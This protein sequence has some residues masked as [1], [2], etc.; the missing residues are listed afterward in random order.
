MN[1]LLKILLLFV[2]ILFLNKN[3]G[4][5]AGTAFLTLVVLFLIWNSRATIMAHFAAQAYFI[6]GDAN[7]GAKLFEKAYKTGVMTSNSKIYYSSFCI[8][9]GRFEKAKHLLTEIIN[10]RFSSD[11]DKIGGKHNMAVVMWREGNLDGA[12][13]LMREVHTKATSTDTYGT[14]GVLLLEKAKET[15]DFEEIRSFMLEAYEYNE[16]D[17]TVADNIGEFYYNTGEFDK[18]TEIYEKLLTK[19]HITPMPYYN[20]ARVL[21]TLGNKE[22]AK[23]MFEKALTCRFT[24][25]ITVNREMIEEELKSL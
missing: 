18:A 20:Y 16:E 17:K 12:I 6:R 8:R 19:E 1:K 7:K 13:D 21:K 4:I 24:S 2:A 10:S 22:K 14:Y 9:E 3:F 23:E 5:W 11:T 25:V 15:G